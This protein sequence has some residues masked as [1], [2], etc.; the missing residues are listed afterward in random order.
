MASITSLMGSSSSTSI[1]GNSN[2][3]S[4]LASGMDTESMIE[5][6]VSG[7]KEKL[8]GY[9]KDRQKL[10]WEQE[11]YQSITD[12]LIAFSD[13]FAPKFSD[14]STDLLSSAFFNSATK[15]SSVGTYK[16]MVSAVGKSASDITI[17]SVTT[18]KK[19]VWNAGT[20]EIN[21]SKA[22]ADTKVTEA[23]IAEGTT[24]RINDKEITI[25]AD[26]TMQSLAS[27]IAKETGLEVVFSDA[28]GAFSL[29]SKE[30]GADAAITFGGDADALDAL[31]KL[32]GRYQN[33]TDASSGD[34]IK[35]ANGN[36]EKEW[37][38]PSNVTGS[39]AIVNMTVNGNEVTI[40]DS[41]TNQL[42]VDGMIL[43][44]KGDFSAD[45]EGVSFNTSVDTDKIVD[46][47]KKMVDEFNTMANEIK[48]AY[49][50]KPLTTS[51]GKRYEPLS[52]EDSKDMSESAIKKYEEKAKTGLL[53]ADS[54]LSALYNELR[55]AANALGYANIGLSTEYEMSS[56][57][58]T[59]KLDEEKLRSTLE[60]DPDKVKDAFTKGVT[61]KGA[62]GESA[63]NGM[64]MMQDTLQKYAKSVGEKG[65]L[66]KLAGTTKIPT[67]LNDNIYKSKM[68]DM[69]ELIK[70][71]EEK[72]TKKID[73][74]TKQF[75]RLEK[76]IS[77]A[78]SQSSAL[79]GLMGY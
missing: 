1:Y 10:E 58:T 45:G 50:T 4:G 25:T 70:R 27:E 44:L 47:I 33:K 2:T 38:G 13:K 35:D 64:Q 12:K 19:A 28:A 24:I 53:F 63:M 60:A 39:N 62:N 73:Y 72:L 78:N 42:T 36:P 56:G 22:T 20:I 32:F 77:D 69:N 43:T 46:T 48:D 16:D 55:A 61:V 49:S 37:V 76:M 8:E 79:M 14:S 54:D 74:Y 23:G 51:K 18:A 34:V 59:L 71:W 26:H 52:E 6:A 65:I 11:A 67:S 15:V 9:N 31:S 41:A 66:I 30:T 7:I 17:N 5:N 40:D 21:G 57:K 68:N 75:T 29:R 3:I